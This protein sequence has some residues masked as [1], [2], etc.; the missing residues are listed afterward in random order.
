MEI[1][2]VS[3][4]N[5]KSCSSFMY[6]NDPYTPRSLSRISHNKEQFGMKSIWKL[7]SFPLPLAAIS[8]LLEIP[9]AKF[10]MNGAEGGGGL[11]F[12]FNV[13]LD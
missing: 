5:Q 11:I 3:N 7:T 10:G 2:S 8:S 12:S 6:V 13:N 4:G 1:T 9:I